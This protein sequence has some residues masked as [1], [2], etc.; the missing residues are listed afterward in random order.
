MKN[1]NLRIISYNNPELF[2]EEFNS[3]YHSS[4]TF[5]TGLLIVPFSAVKGERLPS[6]KYELFS[7]SRTE[8]LILEDRILRKSAKIRELFSQL[9]PIAQKKVL[10]SQM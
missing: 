1:K 2:D 3:R 10:F 4:C 5:R 7:V 8:N 9:P 6:E